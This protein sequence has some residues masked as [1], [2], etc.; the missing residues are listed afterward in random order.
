M[1]DKQ[2]DDIEQ[3]AKTLEQM[4]IAIGEEVEHSTKEIKDLTREVEGVHGRIVTTNH[5]VERLL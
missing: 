3:A 4:G 5:R 1:Q 2:L